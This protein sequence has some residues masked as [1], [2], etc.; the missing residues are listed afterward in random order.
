MPTVSVIAAAHNQ[1]LHIHQ[2]IQS[3]LNQSF[4]DIELIVTDDGSTDGTL[5]VI[6]L[7]S[8][9]A[10]LRVL[11][12]SHPEGVASALSR[13]GSVSTGKYIAWLD[14][15][16]V[17]EKHHLETLVPYL[18]TNVSK[19]GVFGSASLIDVNGDNVGVW[20]DAGIA[21][22]R[23]RLLNLLYSGA[24]PV[25]KSAGL[26]KRESVMEAGHMLPEYG[27]SYDTALWINLLFQGA[28][29][30]IPQAVVR[31]RVQELEAAATE[32]NRSAFENF[33]LLHLFSEQITSI[34]LLLQIFPEIRDVNLPVTDK[35]IQF[36]LAL[37][38]LTND[39]PS[40]RLFG[41]HLLHQLM[42]KPE[43]VALLK[44][45]CGF[46]YRDLFDFEDDLSI[47]ANGSIQSELIDWKEQVENSISAPMLGKRLKPIEDFKVNYSTIL[48][49]WS[50]ISGILVREGPHPDHG[51]PFAFNWCSGPECRLKLTC[52][53]A[54]PHMLVI[55]CQNLQF[56]QITLEVSLP[57]NDVLKFVVNHK[58]GAKTDLLQAVVNLEPG[59]HDVSIKCD[60]WQEETETDERRLAFLLRDI[61]LW[62]CFQL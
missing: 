11:C 4:Q 56:P 17:Y 37:S 60:T 29:D 51:M 45:D 23:F 7:F 13:S 15:N 54:G 20:T 10:R 55:E 32:L 6:R 30:V 21:A 33:E 5:D 44:S 49:G 52:D 25:C 47:L 38:A 43:L 16:D 59:A 58:S 18:E 36:H 12:N 24:R 34:D 3:V 50:S 48:P 61:R 53:K 22:D 31:S 35:F 27:H 8:G 2:A 40:N 42:R 9:D 28:I 1:D 57:G 39:S 41:L 62:E 14:C 46:N 26:V 19:I